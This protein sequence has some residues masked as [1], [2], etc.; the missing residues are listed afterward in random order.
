MSYNTADGQDGRNDPA[1]ADAGDFNR[2]MTALAVIAAEKSA[3]AERE[4][5]IVKAFVGSGG[6]KMALRHARTLSKMDPDDRAMFLAE[7]DYYQGL[8]N[9]HF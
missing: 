7:I 5:D 4:R 3:I 9:L 1:G 8:M 2:T 6:S